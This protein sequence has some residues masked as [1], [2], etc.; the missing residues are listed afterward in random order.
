MRNETT[1]GKM[2][3]RHYNILHCLLWGSRAWQS[4]RAVLTTLGTPCYKSSLVLGHCMLGLSFLGVIISWKFRW[5]LR[6]GQS[7]RFEKKNTKKVLKNI[8]SLCQCF[9]GTLSTW[10][11]E[12]IRLPR[13]QVTWLKIGST[14]IWNPESGNGN[15]ITETETETEYGIC[16]RR[17]QAIDLKKRI[18]AMTMK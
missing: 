6:Q 14:K 16:E 3:S 1:E 11:K 17:F 13:R 15:G 4:P 8:F 12:F 7:Q 2:N 5:L 18:L 10:A 9:G